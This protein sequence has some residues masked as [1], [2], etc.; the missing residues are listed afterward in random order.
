MPF[1]KQTAVA[2][3]LAVAISAVPVAAQAPVAPLK[4]AVMPAPP[5]DLAGMSKT[6]SE[7]IIKLLSFAQEQ[8]KPEERQK[9]KSL[10]AHMALTSSIR[11]LGEYKAT[12][13]IDF[14]LDNVS[15]TFFDVSLSLNS[16]MGRPTVQALVNIGA[17]SVRRIIERLQNP[18]QKSE[19]DERQLREFATI[20]RQ[21]DGNEVGLFRLQQAAKNAEGTGKVNLL[22]LIEIYNRNESIFGV[23]TKPNQVPAVPAPPAAPAPV[24]PTANPQ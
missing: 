3:A 7:N 4:N 14:L 20:I 5:L 13:A 11:L 9:P 21:V 18:L 17:P 1:L 15:E 16:L 19:V 12:E 8:M 22:N 23:P 6:R 24:A 2:L 10:T